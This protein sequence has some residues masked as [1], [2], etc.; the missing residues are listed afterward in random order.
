MEAASNHVRDVNSQI[1]SQLSS[2]MSKLEPLAS[3][4]KGASQVSFNQLQV[5]WNDNARKLNQALND[6]A[7]ALSTSKSTYQ[8]SDEQQASSFGGISGALG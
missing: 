8:S 6:I 4:W 5:R 3:Q 2:L 7:E 1:Q